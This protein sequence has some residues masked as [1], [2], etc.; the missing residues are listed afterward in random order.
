MVEASSIPGAVGPARHAGA[1]RVLGTAFILALT[2]GAVLSIA[3]SL[4]VSTLDGAAWQ[5]ELFGEQAP[6]FALRLDSAVRLPS[7]DAL[8]GLRREQ[9]RGPVEVHFLEYRSR[10]AAAALFRSGPI[11]QDGGASARLKEWEKDPSFAWRTIV[12][13]GELAW[14]AWS[15]KLVLERSFEKGGGWHEEARVDLSTEERGLV[16][17]ARWPAETPADEGELKELLAA[18]V[19]SPKDAF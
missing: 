15:T 10:P 17:F 6:P 11:E 1:G 5:R 4:M 3:K 13:R 18:L 8:L 14:G 16:L 9:G 19:L 7:G 12:K 2:A